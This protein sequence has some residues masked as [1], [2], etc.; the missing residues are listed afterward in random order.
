M[1]DHELFLQQG[2]LQESLECIQNEIRSDASNLDYRIFLFQLL[3]IQGSWDRADKQL[4]VIAKLDDGALAMVHAYRAAIQCERERE[5]VFRAKSDPVFMGK[6]EEWQ[7]LML[8]AL[9][10][11]VEGK[12]EAS[13]ELRVQALELAP[14]LAGTI[15]GEPFEWFADA[16]SRLG[17]ILEVYVEGRY[18]WVP[19]TNISRIE[20]EKPEDLRDMVWMPAHIKW[21]T[22]GESFVLIP[23]RYPFSATQDDMLALSRKTEWDEKGETSYF[24]YGQRLLVSNFND[25]PIL[26]IRQLTF[27]AHSV[28]SQHDEA[29][30]E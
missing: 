16:D 18:M 6:P 29:S 20:I 15:N 26:D 4:D 10:L 5:S 30:T 25:Y 23:T 27:E 21:Q 3:A 2:K 7:A 17:P 14:T 22:E 24:G 8:Q 13:H 1:K 19:F 9:K 28:S 11:T 12:E